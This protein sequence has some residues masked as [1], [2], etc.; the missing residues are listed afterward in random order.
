MPL[1]R[2][3]FLAVL[4][5]LAALAPQAARAHG[6]H[7]RDANPPPALQ[8]IAAIGE[9]APLCPPGTGHLCGCGNL[10]PCDGRIQIAADASPAWTVRPV[11]SW[12]RIAAPRAARL[13]GRPSVTPPSPR[14]P[15][16]S[17]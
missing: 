4:W 13:A 9:A 5:L 12:P 15:P 8:A 2:A 17:S 3:A 1:V 11:A 6:G 14:A 7:E 10:T 16:S